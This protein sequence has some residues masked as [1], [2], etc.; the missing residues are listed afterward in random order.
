MIP[1][2]QKN[3][4]MQKKILFF[5]L[6]LLISCGNK[7]NSKREIITYVG[8]AQGTSF[9]IKYDKNAGNLNSNIDQIFETI[10][11]SV[12]LY[13]PN[14]L[15]M[16]INENDSLGNVDKDFTAIFNLSKKVYAE[17][18]GAFDPTVHPLVSFWGFYKD[19]MQIPENIDSSKIDSLLQLKGFNGSS[20]SAQQLTK[21]NW[22]VKFDFNGIAQGYTVD[23]I[24]EMFDSYAVNNYM[25]E[26]GGEVRAK[27]INPDGVVWKIGIDKPVPI[28]ETRELIAIAS[29][30]NL[31]LAT[32]G[33]YRKYYEKDGKKYS[34][35]IDP[36]TGYPVKHSLISVSVF[37]KSCAEADALA[38]AFMVMGESN[39]K[40]FLTKRTDVFV[41][42]IMANYK[43]EW[44]TYMSEGLKSK[45]ELLKEN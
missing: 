37:T 27:G 18:N 16:K 3:N 31:S 33:N 44:E 8:Y 22:K 42:M 41:Y 35:T 21:E 39:T 38:T 14:S 29:L 15:L 10:D 13:N 5:I 4:S 17:T 40:K 28:N 36:F 7:S 25:I 32:S 2:I 1:I 6:F 12:S 11:N 45:L 20:I 23:K 9:S 24:A 43:G 26:I 30:E 19:K 34:H